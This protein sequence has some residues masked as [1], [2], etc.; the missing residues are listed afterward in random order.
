M[1]YYIT[2]HMKNGDKWVTIRDS[3]E[4]MNTVIECIVKDK[5][6]LKFT[7]EEK[8][9]DH[10]ERDDLNRQ[11]TNLRIKQKELKAE[12]E[13]LL[14]RNAEHEKRNKDRTY[15][16]LDKAELQKE[17]DERMKR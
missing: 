2:S 8:L 14:K 7:V 3:F 15:A 10:E 6:V 9:N 4:E 12:N 13:F 11:I 1:R 16:I 17:Y 5:E